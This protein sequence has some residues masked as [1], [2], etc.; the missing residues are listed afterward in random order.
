MDLFEAIR[1]RRSIRRFTE[2]PVPEVD[3]R[4]A[5]EA[6]IL[7]PNS[8]N[9]QT[10]DFF[11]VRSAEK[12]SRLIEACLSQ[13]AARTAAEL[14]VVSANPKN[15]QRSRPL[16]IEWVKR[17]G[18]PKPVVQYYETLIPLMY[19]WGFLNIFGVSK[20]LTMSI[21]GVFR[22]VPRGPNTKRDMQEVAIKSAALAAQNLVLAL[23]AKGHQTCMM[24]GFDESRVR[25]LLKISRQNRIVMVIAVGEPQVKGTWG[26]QFRLPVESVLHEV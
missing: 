15:W 4:A 1:T 21:V 13:S 25:R 2:K 24:E 11:W 19:R 17:V 18:A 8:S 5:I 10:W 23:T 3:I 20:M 6:A 26:P 9:T 14:I 16:L 12:K 7:A 22:P